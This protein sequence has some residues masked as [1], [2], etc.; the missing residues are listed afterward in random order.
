MG[1]KERLEK[2]F[3]LA[4]DL[5][6]TERHWEAWPQYRGFN[7][8]YSGREKDHPRYNAFIDEYGGYT[9][10]AIAYPSTRGYKNMQVTR[11]LIDVVDEMIENVWS[12]KKLQPMAKNIHEYYSEL[13]NKEDSDA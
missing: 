2:L 1:R 10:I 3:V 4:D 8:I 6:M 11:E 13:T 5:T 12:H 9:S 7:F